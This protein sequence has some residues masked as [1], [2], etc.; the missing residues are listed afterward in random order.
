[1]RAKVL[2]LKQKGIN[3]SM[4]WLCGAGIYYIQRRTLLG[5]DRGT[6]RFGAPM[7]SMITAIAVGQYSSVPL[8]REKN[9]FYSTPPILVYL[10]AASALPFGSEAEPQSRF[11]SSTMFHV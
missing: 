4:T 5:K 2:A 1:M 10:P 7:E 9:R 11:Q 3:W 8:A 6:D